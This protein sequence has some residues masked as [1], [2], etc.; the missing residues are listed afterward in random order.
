MQNCLIHENNYT[1]AYPAGWEAGGGKMTGST[2]ALFYQNQSWGNHGPGFW[3]DIYCHSTTFRAN[4]AWQ[5]RGPGIMEEVSYDALIEDNVCWQNFYGQ[6]H[7]WVDSASILVHSSTGVEVRNNVCY[8]TDIGIGIDCQTRADW[9]LIHPVS[10]IYI[11][12]NNVIAC[13]TLIAWATIRGEA[14]CIQPQ[15][16]RSK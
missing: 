7:K 15:Q 11:H 1:D 8:A 4:R 16:P 5:N 14:I 2:G 9:P 6:G 10:N 12:D 3:D 13:T